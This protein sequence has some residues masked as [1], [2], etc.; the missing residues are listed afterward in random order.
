MSV[1]FCLRSV[2]TASLAGLLLLG[3]CGKTKLT[4]TATD[5]E[6]TVA[7]VVV[8]SAGKPVSGARVRLVSDPLAW[9]TSSNLA[10]IA[11]NTD[12][13]SAQLRETISGT[14][15]EFSF[16]NVDS[17]LV[18]SLS[19]DFQNSG[20]HIQAKLLTDLTLAGASADTVKTVQLRKAS[21]LIGKLS[22]IRGENPLYQ[23]SD[24]FRVG[25]EN[26]G[27][28]IPVLVN[29]SFTLDGIPPGLQ[30]LVIYPADKFLMQSLIEAGIPLDSLVQR[31]VM[32]FPDGDT[33]YAQEM[34]WQLP[35]SFA[36]LKP[37]SVVTRRHMMTGV[38]VS[39]QGQPLPNIEVRVVSDSLGFAFDNLGQVDFPASDSVW[40]KTNAH[41][42]W[43]LPVPATGAFNLEALRFEDDSIVGVGLLKGLSAKGLSDSVNT[44]DTISL[45]APAT[46]RG[47][48]L[49]TAELGNWIQIGS[50]FRLGIQGTSRYVDINVGD[51][52]ELTGLP[53][54]V[55]TLVFYPGDSFLW[56][57]FA[58]SLGSLEAMVKNTSTL[59]LSPGALQQMQ[60]V[61]YTLPA[62]PSP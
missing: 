56:P 60:F 9:T 22:Y 58:D 59:G 57:T 46:L 1:A 30:T 61:T 11:M 44:I 15:G 39:L 4:G 28:V 10:R 40:T 54:G 51:T 35:K 14:K 24:Q 37:D 5:T 45:E 2:S 49:Y 23:F 25:I 7:G 33:V 13:T 43:S 52:Y 6:N 42:V 41:G 26:S 62:I 38:V 31:V 17:G 53:K 34:Q 47:Q 3:G 20:E 48:L 16:E 36:W 8:D 32:D 50:H 55:Q 19:F 29:R 21:T 12:D 18:F 27:A